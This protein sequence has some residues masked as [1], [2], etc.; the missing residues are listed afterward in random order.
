ME[1]EDTFIGAT[2]ACSVSAWAD[3]PNAFRVNVG[4]LPVFNA[5]AGATYIGCH[6]SYA[7]TGMQQPALTT[8]DL[9]GVEIGLS[10]AAISLPGGTPNGSFSVF[11]P[12]SAMADPGGEAVD[13]AAYWVGSDTTPPYATTKFNVL[14]AGIVIRRVYSEPCAAGAILQ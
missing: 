1:T 7:W 6:V 5:P 9:V 11:V 3:A 4:T 2:L 10:Q 8:R 13:V 12:A 14:F